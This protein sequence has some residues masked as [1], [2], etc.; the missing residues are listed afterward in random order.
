MTYL[1]L[2]LIWGFWVYKVPKQ[3]RLLPILAFVGFLC[4]LLYQ[5]TRPNKL[6]MDNF[7]YNGQM[8]KHVSSYSDSTHNIYL[9][10]GDDKHV[11]IDSVGIIE[12]GILSKIAIYRE[13]KGWY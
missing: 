6:K 8:Y 2:L 13:K 5:E 7:I 9:S 1:V 3:Q 4:F 12:T 10:I 11:N